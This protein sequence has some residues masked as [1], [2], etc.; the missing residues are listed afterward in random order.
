MLNNAVLKKL[1]YYPAR[2][3]S[4]TEL[5]IIGRTASRFGKLKKNYIVFKNRTMQDMTDN[6]RAFCEYLTSHEKYAKYKII[7]MVSDKKKFR[8]K[9]Y[10]NIKFVTAENRYG[11][12]SPLAYYYGA[13]AG[14]FFYTNNTAYLNLYHCKGQVT[15][16]MWHGCGYKDAAKESRD[17][18][19]KKSMMHFDCALVPG[20]VL[21]KRKP[22]TGIVKNPGSFRWGIQD[23]T[24]CYILPQAEKKSSGNCL[25]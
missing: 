23:M 4:K 24:G 25:E 2:L 5:Q 1:I 6:P 13:V 22:D 19:G 16:N 12:T 3:M 11:W 14:H 9:E 18:S 21:Q 10:K 15:V 17:N 8:K 20:P 7:W